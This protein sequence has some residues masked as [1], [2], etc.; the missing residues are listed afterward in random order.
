M[1]PVRYSLGLFLAGNHAT[2][3]ERL[4]HGMREVGKFPARAFRK[5]R[6]AECMGRVLCSR[7]VENWW[8]APL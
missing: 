5:A 4:G 7:D 2:Q 3:P 6:E 1:L 8:R